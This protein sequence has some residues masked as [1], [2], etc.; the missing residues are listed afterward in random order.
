MSELNPSAADAR[1][2]DSVPE[3]YDL[4]LG[5]LFFGQY[6][7]DLATRLAASERPVRKVLEIAAGTGILTEQLARLLPAEA[8]IVATD[9]NPPMLAVAQKRLQGEASGSRIEWREADATTLPFSDGS[10]DAVVCQFGCMFFPDKPRAASETHRVLA[11]GGRWLFNVWGSLEENPIPRIAH[12]TITSY[13]TDDPPQ[14]YKVPFSMHEEE[15]TRELVAGAGFS[16]VTVIPLPFAA[17]AASARHAAIGL[18]RGNPVLAAI[19]ER[20]TVGADEI[21]EAI[22]AALAREL[23]DGPL[24][25]PMLAY[26]VSG[27]KAPE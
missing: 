16:D 19:E 11:P 17:E 6:A 9:L 21:I 13:F 23:G 8:S 18:V 26:V 2:V 3:I 14:F 10:F 20:G 24:R 22:A 4:H 5:P 15:S 12:E 25:A 27:R 7:R 1:F